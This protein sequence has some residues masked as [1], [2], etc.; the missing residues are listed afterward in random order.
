MEDQYR[1]VSQ[2]PSEQ[3]Q[4]GVN[5]LVLSNAAE[6]SNRQKCSELVIWKPPVIWVRVVSVERWDGDT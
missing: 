4:E 5:G 2:M 3:S 1:M 6:K